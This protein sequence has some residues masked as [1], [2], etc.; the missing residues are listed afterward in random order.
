MCEINTKG[1]KLG[2]ILITCRNG[3][4][5]LPNFF[6]P[7]DLSRQAYAE[8][9]TVL[10]LLGLLHTVAKDRGNPIPG[11]LYGI[12]MVGWLSTN[13]TGTYKAIAIRQIV[14]LRRG[15]YSAITNILL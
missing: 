6:C 2:C 13:L 8:R 3:A 7:L 5:R 4:E 1:K 12:D 14:D 10:A 15:I 9:F 11:A